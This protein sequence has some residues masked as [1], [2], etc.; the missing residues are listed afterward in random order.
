[1]NNLFVF[2][3]LYIMKYGVFMLWNMVKTSHHGASL[4]VLLLFV[5]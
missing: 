3:L 2:S 1:M 5:G 4:G